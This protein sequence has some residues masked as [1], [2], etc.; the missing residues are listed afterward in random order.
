VQSNELLAAARM[1]T[2]ADL[3]ASTVTQVLDAL[4]NVGKGRID[5]LDAATEHLWPEDSELTGLTAWAQGHAIALQVREALG[6]SIDAVFNPLEWLQSA[7]VDVRVIRLRTRYVDAVSCW[8]AHR[9]PAVLLNSDGLHGSTERARR[10]TLA[11]EIGHLIMD[12]YSALPAAEVLTRSSRTSVESRANAFAAELLLPRAYVGK[13]FQ[14]SSDEDE[15]A[16]LVDEVSERFG[17]GAELVAW[18]AHN[19]S[20]PLTPAAHRALRRR[21]SFRDRPKFDR[22]PSSAFAY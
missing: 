5:L 19:G 2:D 9:G 14:T 22:P 12:R 8:G 15:A 4:A 20:W 7:G 18:Q 16:V 3:P 6:M 1:T 11:H 21:V 13:L 17:V 10:A